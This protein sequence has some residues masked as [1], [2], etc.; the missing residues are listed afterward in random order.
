[1]GRSNV[2]TLLILL[3]LLS[4]RLA[5]Q[6]R[7]D[8][9][10]DLA[11]AKKHLEQFAGSEKDENK[12]Q[13]AAIEQRI[14]LLEEM[15]GTREQEAALPD[16][17]GLEKEKEEV[18]NDI[19]K[20]RELPEPRRV[21]L[22]SPAEL[23]TYEERQRNA[24]R[25]RDEAIGTIALLGERRAKATEEQ[26]T[27]P[28]RE[29]EA[30]RRL[31]SLTGED[32]LSKY[33]AATARLE[34]A[35]VSARRHLLEQGGKL[36]TI[37]IPIRQQQ[38]DLADTLLKH[39]EKVLALAREAAGTLRKAKAEED[40]EKARAA[41]EAAKR[42]ADPIVRFAG[43]KKAEAAT[44]RSRTLAGAGKAD[45]VRADIRRRKE[46]IDR[47]RLEQK[48]I[49]KRLEFQDPGV[50]DLLR[51]S[52]ER[53]EKALQNL[54]R[55]VTPKIAEA[56]ARTQKALI[57][58]LDR[59]WKL[60]LPADEN[61][62]FLELREGLPESRWSE[63]EKTFREVM[64]GAEGLLAALR[65]ERTAL[66]GLEA[67]HGERAALVVEAKDEFRR[68]M[69]FARANL[70]FSRSDAPL[71][72]S[73]FVLALEEIPKI[74]GI[75]SDP[76]LWRKA[77][78][79]V[80][81]LTR[82]A[83]LLL[84]ALLLSGAVVIVPRYLKRRRR[85][86]GEAEETGVPTFMGR[87]PATVQFII[88]LL[89]PAGL[90]LTG[91]FAA[92]LALPSPL[93]TVVPLVFQAIAAV[94][95]VRR[96]A[97]WFLHP[98]GPGIHIVGLV[99]E[100][101]ARIR[102]IVAIGTTA[103]MLL[104]VPAVA[105]GESSPDLKHLP[106]LLDTAWM[107]ILGFCFVV[108]LSRRGP[109]IRQIARPGKLLDRL[110]IV[111]GPLLVLAVLALVVL[112]IGGYRVAA[113][114]FMRNLVQSFSIVILVVALYAILV[115]IIGRIAK[116]VRKRMIVEEGYEAAQESS[117]AVT[118]QLTRLCA[119][120]ILAVTLLALLSSWDDSLVL[121]EILSDV[122]IMETGID[123]YLTL[124]EVLKAILFIAAGHFV[125]AN[126]SG[127]YEFIVFP[128]L[129][130]TD[131]GGQYVLLAL[132]RY[133][134]LLVAYGAALIVLGLQMSSI[135]W[136]L[137]AASV[138]IGFGLQEIIA[139]FVAG[140]IILFER[141]IQ[142][143]DIITVDDTEGTVERI[144]IRATI[145]TN[146]DRQAIVIPNKDFI[147]KKLTNWTRN[148]DIMRRRIVVRA[149]IGTDVPKL[150]SALDETV[151][152][153]PKVLTDPPH[154]VWIWGYQESGLEVM[155]FFFTK[156]SDGLQTRA[157]LHQQI[158]ERLAEEN[159]EIAIPRRRIF[160]MHD[161]ASADLDL[162]D[163]PPAEE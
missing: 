93:G 141:P 73:T 50:S 159:I 2:L 100:N 59:I 151:G 30:K 75:Y 46:M 125:V 51:H 74:V 158:Y 55:N 48:Y 123:Q 144:T 12:R 80:K 89:P 137:A 28:S 142:V 77:S 155:V 49:E 102:R 105:I 95:A 138:G 3:V 161:P 58:V 147:T 107:A 26:K 44:V 154:R 43:L 10:A 68:F 70:V 47:L 9:A 143:G 20:A 35:V 109:L 13:A 106:R 101:A 21:I 66:E 63:A 88:A 97:A 134:I 72:G 146:W 15:I 61:P 128:L 11:E 81:D 31:D 121:F 37:V 118:E 33:Q 114:T 45:Q 14:R 22:K 96:L 8:H 145:V 94:L 67:L 129:G 90:L 156:I 124:L 150:L 54:R 69:E 126:L 108:L 127:V 120:V 17:V 16:A 157:E 91:L 136:L 82:A 62:A 52:Q 103:G 32:D 84:I 92:R 160:V 110:W 4:S 85:D 36:Y 117:S 27:L 42:E 104:A 19:R 111:I 60:Q 25:V 1:V 149:G 24:L 65:D 64:D 163:E 99:P 6:E 7:P 39:E 131:R 34:S 162:P 38:L 57:D 133:V 56:S 122:K 18:E 23:S 53:A 116:Q 115:R 78:T 29:A 79:H 130:S 5:A 112:E 40:R 71:S 132:S 87:G 148:D 41:E 86:S 76:E 135:T 83:L 152:A 98:N 140:L 153:H 113:W 119:I 139:N